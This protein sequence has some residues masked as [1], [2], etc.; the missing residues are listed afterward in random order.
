M[1]SVSIHAHRPSSARPGRVSA[2]A[3]PGPIVTGHSYR[4]AFSHTSG[5]YSSVAQA[6]ST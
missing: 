5:A 3:T 2:A 6:I 1:K 4:H